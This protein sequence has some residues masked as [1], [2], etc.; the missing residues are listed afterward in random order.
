[1]HETL[2]SFVAFLSGARSALAVSEERGIPTD[3]L[4]KTGENDIGLL[5]EFAA[6]KGCVATQTLVGH[7]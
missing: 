2:S 4:S 6:H 3:G 7:T 1:M 5:L